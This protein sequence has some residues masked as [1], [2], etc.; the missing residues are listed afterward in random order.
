[1]TECTIYNTL[2]IV[3]KKWSLL[4]LLELYRGKSKEKRFN[5]LKR[6]LR[7]ITPKI[8]SLRLSELENQGLINKKIDNSNVPVKCE[9]SLTESGEDFIHIIQEIKEWGLKW[10]FNNNACSVTYCKQ[11]ELALD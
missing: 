10:K 11:C 3:G 7:G 4:I 5:E 8:L 1:M 2:D 6:G 9:Y